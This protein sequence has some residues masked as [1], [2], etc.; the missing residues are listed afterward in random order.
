M[1]TA[2]SALNTSL[3]AVRT[4][5]ED[6]C[7]RSDRQLS[8]VKLVAVS[9]TSPASVLREAL[10]AGVAI[11]GEN[12]VQ[13]AEGK[14]AE[15]GRDAAEW[16]LIGHLQSNKARKAVQLF[17]VIH[18]VDSVELATRLERICIEEDRDSLSIFVQVDLAGEETKSGIPEADLPKLVEY[19]RT[20][21]RL[22]FDGLMI[23]P[24]F[25]DDADQMRPYF[26]RIRSI[27][28]ELLAS[29]AFANAKG[30]LSMGMSGDYEAAIEE[31]STIVRVG[32]A[33]FG[34]REYTK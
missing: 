2:L 20:C 33:I 11:F 34:E 4:R 23:L 3:T 22:K 25:L 26:R 10:D 6:V 7:V 24:P 32:T 8:D 27:R 1:Q 5:I 18:S 21:E 28:D 31:G 16:H 29:G 12:K 15:I 13:E 9:K 14:I 17:D 19:L 30:E